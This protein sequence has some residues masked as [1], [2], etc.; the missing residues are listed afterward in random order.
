MNDT[1]DQTVSH[2]TFSSTLVKQATNYCVGIIR[3][4]SLFI[5]PINSIYQMRPDFSHCNPNLEQDNKDDDDA[6]PIGSNIPIGTKKGTIVNC[7]IDHNKDNDELYWYE[8]TRTSTRQFIDNKQKFLEENV[9]CQDTVNFNNYDRNRNKNDI[10]SSILHQKYRSFHEIPP[11]ISLMDARKLPQTQSIPYYMRDCVVLSPTQIFRQLN[12]NDHKAKL[13]AFRVII[14]HGYLVH[15]RYIVRHKFLRDSA[16]KK[17]QKEWNLLVHLFHDK[18]GLITRLDFLN[19]VGK[20]K[21]SKLHNIDYEILDT[22]LRLLSNEL[23]PQQSKQI[24]LK[25]NLNQIKDNIIYWKLKSNDND[26]EMLRLEFEETYNKSIKHLQELIKQNHNEKEFDFNYEENDEYDDDNDI[27]MDI[28]TNIDTNTFDDNPYT[29]DDEEEDEIQDQNHNHNQD[30]NEDE[31]DDLIMNNKQNNESIKYQ[32]CRKFMI[33][34]LKKNKVL[35][36]KNIKKLID[37]YSRQY[38][39][40]MGITD[41]TIEAARDDICWVIQDKLYVL[42]ESPDH[43][44]MKQYDK[45]RKKIVDWF[46]KHDSKQKIKDSTAAKQWK[47]LTK[48]SKETKQNYIMTMCEFDESNKVWTL[49]TG[50]PAKRRR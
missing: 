33:Q 40:L 8:N 37:R 44:N 20:D 47:S 32:S 5:N 28:T 14:N 21:N 36:M 39:T 4:N 17:Y 42:K 3:G 35:D 19:I 6:N 34:K 31:D 13:N 29:F 23:S 26:T 9:F 15:G 30:E 18:G 41:D 46:N 50:V 22:M 16:L 38:P 43:D 11:G 27:D 48:P 7:Q 12:I 10:Q 25:R 45:H 1:M 49:K 2:M 24:Q